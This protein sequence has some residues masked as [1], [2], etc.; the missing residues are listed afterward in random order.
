M[1]TN[2]TERERDVWKD[3]YTM[4]ETVHDMK[5]TADEWEMFS[6]RIMA[7]ADGY[8]GQ[9]RRLLIRMGMALYEYMSEEQRIR[10]EENRFAPK[11][12]LLEEIP[13]N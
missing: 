3:L 12:I 1:T 9:E 10:E 2:L 5:G 6:K 4:H 13:W 8:Q 11:Q 7:A